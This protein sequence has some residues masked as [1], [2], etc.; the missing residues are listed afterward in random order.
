MGHYVEIDVISLGVLHR[1]RK[2]IGSY[3]R[4]GIAAAFGGKNWDLVL[5]IMLGI[6]KS[7]MEK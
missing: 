7:V 3:L 4:K 1:E 6:R 5:N 2:F